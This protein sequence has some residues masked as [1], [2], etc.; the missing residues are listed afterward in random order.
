MRGAR[1]IL[2]YGDVVMS[3]KSKSGMIC[4]CEVAKVYQ[5]PRDGSALVCDL[6]CGTHVDINSNKGGKGFY[7]VDVMEGVS[8]F[9]KK[10]YIRLD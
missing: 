1:E 10:E 3:K 4:N 9:V 7:G 6:L 8:G 5:T 2:A